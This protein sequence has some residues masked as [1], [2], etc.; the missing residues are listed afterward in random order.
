[1]FLVVL[2]CNNDCVTNYHIIPLSL[3]PSIILPAV[4]PNGQGVDGAE[5]VPDGVSLRSF[6]SSRVTGQS[7]STI[8]GTGLHLVK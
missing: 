1:M 4:P 7:D 8:T 2:F 6:A 5:D 3:P